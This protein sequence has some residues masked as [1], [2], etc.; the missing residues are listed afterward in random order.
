M[1]VCR[2]SVICN[3]SLTSQL[4]QTITVC[5]SFTIV[6][7]NPCIVFSVHASHTRSVLLFWTSIHPTLARGQCTW[8]LNQP[9][10]RIPLRDCALSFIP[11]ALPYTAL[12]GTLQHIAAPPNTLQHLAAPCSTLQHQLLQHIMGLNWLLLY[13][14]GVLNIGT[15]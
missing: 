8:M 2:R 14:W 1:D 4:S 13:Y 12:C 3:H 10:I 5:L 9:Y 7:F 6:S 11:T 15:T